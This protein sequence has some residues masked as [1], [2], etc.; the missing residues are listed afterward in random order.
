M[1]LPAGPTRAVQTTTSVLR[2]CSGVFARTASRRGEAAPPVHE[3]ASRHGFDG[4]VVITSEDD[5]EQAIRKRFVVGHVRRRLAG[6]T[7][8]VHMLRRGEDAGDAQV[9]DAHIVAAQTASVSP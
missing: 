4:F 8:T 1:A 6:T 3:S 5:D 7:L 2:L 9:V